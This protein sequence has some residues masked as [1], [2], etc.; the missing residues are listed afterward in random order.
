MSTL[1]TYQGSL[2][3][4]ILYSLREPHTL[5]LSAVYEI[6]QKNNRVANLKTI[7][8][9]SSI[10]PLIDKENYTMSDISKLLGDLVLKN[11]LTHSS[12]VIDDKTVDAYAIS[13]EALLLIKKSTQ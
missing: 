9:H 6:T 11:L 12:P 7:C 13:E 8:E 2:L 5:F 1:T 4:R 10:K 3:E